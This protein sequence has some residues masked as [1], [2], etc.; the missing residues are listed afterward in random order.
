[1][2]DLNSM[3]G[4]Q[5]SRSRRFGR[6]EVD[7]FGNLSGDLNPLHFETDAARQ[8]RFKQPI[9]HGMLTAS[10]I[11]SVIGQDLPGPGTVYVSQTLQFRAPVFIGETVT[12]KVEVIAVR[13]DKPLLTLKTTCTAGDG[14]VVLEG[15]AVVWF[16]PSHA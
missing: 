14:R 11:S 3:V 2:N 15:E 9:V 16:D 5:A 10:L 8:S 13:P 1:M 4:K 6:P 12:A 7:T